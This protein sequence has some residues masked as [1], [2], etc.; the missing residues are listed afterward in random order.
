MAPSPGSGRRRPLL[1]SV[2]AGGGALPPT[3]WAQGREQPRN[4]YQKALKFLG[5]RDVDP[6][7]L[8]YHLDVLH[9]VV[10][11]GQREGPQLSLRRPEGP[12][13][14]GATAFTRRLLLLGLLALALLVPAPPAHRSL[15]LSSTA[16]PP[17]CL[18]TVLT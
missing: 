14:W 10:E 6:A 3:L 15:G 4:P 7:V 13:L 16:C 18:A 2:A 17:V 12:K 9:L 5:L 8:L 11:P 1:L